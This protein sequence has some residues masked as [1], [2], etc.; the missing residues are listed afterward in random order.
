MPRKYHWPCLKKGVI[1]FVKT[2]VKCQVKQ[3]S[4]QKQTG[5]LQPFP[6]LSGPWHSMSMDI[7]TSLSESLGDGI[8]VCQVGTHGDDCD[9]CN[10]VGDHIAISQCIVAAP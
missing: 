6:I 2:C 8:S 4:Y 9:Y 1:H 10:H 3:T 7:I 5:L